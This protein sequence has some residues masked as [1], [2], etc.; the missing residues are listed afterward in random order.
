M[1]VFG[2]LFLFLFGIFLIALGYMFEEKLRTQFHVYAPVAFIAAGGLVALV[3][4]LTYL[5]MKYFKQ[6]RFFDYL[7][8]SMV[9]DM[10]IRAA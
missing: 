1:G 2:V 3:A 7:G 6:G 9:T 4:G 8:V 5:R 10:L